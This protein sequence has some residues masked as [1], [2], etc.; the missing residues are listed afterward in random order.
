[1]YVWVRSARGGALRGGPRWWGGSPKFYWA[2]S[3]KFET[4]NRNPQAQSIGTFLCELDKRGGAVCI[5]TSQS[6]TRMGVSRR[7]REAKGAP[8]H[9]KLAG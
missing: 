8:G 1:M 6:H 9:S 3:W 7:E 2:I 4:Y 5:P